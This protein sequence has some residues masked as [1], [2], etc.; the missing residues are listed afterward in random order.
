MKHNTPHFGLSACLAIL[1]S[2][3]ALSAQD[4]PRTVVGNA[5]DYYDNLIFGS[6]HFTVGEVAVARYQNGLELGEGFHRAYYDLLVKNEELLPLDWAVNIYPNPTTESIRIAL[7]DL[8]PTQAALYNT[9]GQLLWQETIVTPL[10]VVDLAA[11]PAGTYL[12][13]LADEEGR[14]G[15]FQVLKIKH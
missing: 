14:T 8:A 12:L 11:Y 2:A 4:I 10:Q 13:R 9:N 6:L 5:G 3:G 15:T 7:P 1:L